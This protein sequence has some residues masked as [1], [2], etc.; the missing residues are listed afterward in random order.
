[1]PTLQFDDNEI[2]AVIDKVVERD[3][4]SYRN[5]PHKRLQGWG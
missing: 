2:R 1:M 4:E 3:I 5:V